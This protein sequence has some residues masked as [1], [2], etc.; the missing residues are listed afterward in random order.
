MGKRR[1]SQAVHVRVPDGCAKAVRWQDPHWRW[2]PRYSRVYTCEVG[3]TLVEVPS[4]LAFPPAPTPRQPALFATRELRV[5]HEL[6][7]ALV[8]AV[9]PLSLEP[10][11]LRGVK[12]A[13]AVARLSCE[14]R[15]EF[16]CMEG[17]CVRVSHVVQYMYVQNVQTAALPR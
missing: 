2:L 4:K 16:C 10:T 8:Q 5:P 15:L 3:A 7:A 17:R 14:Q 6:L 12:Y 11:H 13:E 1:V 9:Q